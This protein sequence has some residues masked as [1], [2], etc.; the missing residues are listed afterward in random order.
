MYLSPFK[1]TQPFILY[2]TNSYKLISLNKKMAWSLYEKKEGNLKSIDKFLPPLKF[3]NNK[4]QEDVVSEILQEIKKGT[5]IIFIRGICGT[6]KSAIALNLAKEVGKASI[7]VPVKSLQKQYEQDYTENKYLLKKNKEKLK[8]KTITGRGNFKCPYLKDNPIK[9]NQK[10]KN[11]TLDIFDH[12]FPLID[13]KKDPS[14]DNCFLPCK[15]QIKDKNSSYIREYLKKNPRIQSPNSIPINRVRRLS[16]AP[17]CPYWS[18]LIP[19]EINLDLLDDAETLKYKGLENKEYTIYKRKS[20]CQ[21]Y[22]Q[23]QSYIDSDVLIFNSLKYKIETAMDRKPLTDIEIIDE[24]DEFLDS[25]SNQQTININRLNF[26]L[27][28]LFT[29]S[30]KTQKTIT[31]LTKLTAEIIK[32]EKSKI[33]RED[34]IPLNETKILEIINHFIESDLMNYVECDEENYCFHVEE[35][36]QTFKQFIDETFISIQKEENQI[37]I[38]LVTTNLEKRFK[39]L[40][41][42]SKI[43]VLMSG[44]IHSEKVLNEVFGIQDFK[45]IDAETE[46]PGKITKQKTGL[47]INCKYSN[48]QSGKTT[49]EEYLKALEKC[50]LTAKPPVLVHV[51]SFKDLPTQYE[52]DKLGLQL[53]TQ[54]KLRELQYADSLGESIKKFKQGEFPILY[55]TKCNRG[56]DFPGETCNSIVLT[57]YPYPN[58][59]SLFW[60]VLRQTHP[61]HYNSFYLDKSTREFLQRIFR[62]LRSK[63]DHIFLLSPDIRV[64]E[65][66]HLLN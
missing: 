37:L 53:M 39:E 57:K 35:V 52:A 55:S 16:I 40:I 6:G 13:P 25:F 66:L 27:G 8:I 9:E 7:V 23:Y 62:A 51:N 15:I 14:C 47:E 60:Q 38:K 26:A 32:E 22:D 5:K 12:E 48:F 28:F 2:N 31:E 63:T 10:A 30:D 46:T 65:N 33:A 1:L 24:C 45:I 19:S 4:T 54:G 3:S 29:D 44:T 20:G 11:S 17:V 61:Q 50:I 21:Y 49:R 42:K 59:S 41:N 58:V 36:A 34:I 56:I 64:F 18:P 43:F